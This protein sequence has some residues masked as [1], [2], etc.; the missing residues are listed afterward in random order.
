MIAQLDTKTDIVLWKSVVSIEKYLQMAKEPAIL[1]LLSWMWIISM[2]YHFKTTRKHNI[3]PLIGL[4]NRPWSKM[5][6]ISLRF[7]ALSTKRLSEL[8][9]LSHFKMTGRK[10]WSDFTSRLE[11][12]AIIVPYVRGESNS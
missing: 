8:M 10:K 2:E 6:R 3:Q 11:D 9:K 12:V 5:R 1:T 4:R 7:L